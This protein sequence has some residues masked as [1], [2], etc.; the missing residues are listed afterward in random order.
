MRHRVEHALVVADEEYTGR[1]LYLG[2]DR[3]GNLLEIVTVLRDDDTEIV[4]HAMRM[5]RIYEPLLG[6]IGEP[7]G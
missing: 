2:P 6:E 4:I 1:V 5:R 3:A 7:N